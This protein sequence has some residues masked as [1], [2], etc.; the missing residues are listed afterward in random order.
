MFALVNRRQ[1]LV[2][3][4]SALLKSVLADLHE[5]DSAIVDEALVERI[6][7]LE[8]LDAELDALLARKAERPREEF[9]RVLERLA[10]PYRERDEEGRTPT[11]L[12]LITN[13]PPSRRSAL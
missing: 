11:R 10:T 6:H 2:Q 8:G 5:R 12:S 13:A 1:E 4:D 7:A 9:L 3:H